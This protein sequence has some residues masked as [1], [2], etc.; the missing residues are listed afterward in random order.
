MRELGAKGGSV[1]RGNAKLR[2]KIKRSPSLRDYLRTNVE[3][4]EVW[5]ALSLAL[6]NGG[7][8]GV[9]A[10]KLLIDALHEPEREKERDLSLKVAAE[11]FHRKFGDRM[12]RSHA[13]RQHQLREILRPLGL[14]ELAGEDGDVNLYETELEIV[15]ELARRLAAVPD[16]VRAELSPLSE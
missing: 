11:E 13:W 5:R 15:R 10:S 8:A 9:S 7:A 2:E 6:E 14:V 1:G 3:P 12:E 4:A 16:H